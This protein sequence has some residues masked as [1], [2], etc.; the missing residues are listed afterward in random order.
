LTFASRVKQ[1]SCSAICQSS[2]TKVLASNTHR[3]A[4][5]FVHHIV[6]QVFKAYCDKKSLD[7]E[8]VRCD[9]TSWSRNCHA[10]LLPV[11]VLPLKCFPCLCGLGHTQ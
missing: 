5:C 7:S 4:W 11:A 9:A 6:A 1:V 2:G 10:L 8:A 3:P